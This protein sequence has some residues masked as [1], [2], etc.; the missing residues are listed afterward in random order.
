MK[1]NQLLSWTFLLVASGPLLAHPITESAEMPYS[2]PVS[3]E[4]RGVGS[5]DDLSLS[6]QSYPPQD[7]GLRYSTL[8]SGELNRDS[9]RTTGLLPRGMKREVLLEKQALLNPFSHFLGIR[10][11]FR[12]RGGNSECFWKYCV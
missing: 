8:V 4:D 7:A 6:E 12:K 9:V 10:K 11:Q 5:L 1:C 3:V 2:G